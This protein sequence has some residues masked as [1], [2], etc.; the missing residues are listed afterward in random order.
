LV[1]DLNL[2]DAR[3]R[4][5]NFLFRAKDQGRAFRI[6]ILAR[7]QSRGVTSDQKYRCGPLIFTHFHVCIWHAS[8][9]IPA[10]VT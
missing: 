4:I 9:D 1:R 2:K 3:L 10:Y 8:T 5:S 6:T 7:F